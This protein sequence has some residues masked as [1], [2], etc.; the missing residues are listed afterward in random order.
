MCLCLLNENNITILFIFLFG[1]FFSIFFQVLSI[2]PNNIPV[3]YSAINLE[4][5]YQHALPPHIFKL[6]LM[7]HN[8]APTVRKE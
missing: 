8:R 6:L 1:V 7:L 3:S 4:G 5:E 2:Q